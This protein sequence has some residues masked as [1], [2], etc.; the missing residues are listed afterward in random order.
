VAAPDRRNDVKYTAG[1]EYLAEKLIEALHAFLCMDEMFPLSTYLQNATLFNGAPVIACVSYFMT[2]CRDNLR[3]QRRGID[4]IKH[5]ADNQ[6]GLS[7]IAMHS[8]SSILHAARTLSDTLEVQYSFCK[9]VAAEAKSDDFARENFIRFGV[10]TLLVE[11][12]LRQHAE[13]SKQACMALTE[14]CVHD[15]DIIA[16]CQSAGVVDAVLAL[17]DSMRADYPSR[18][19]SNAAKSSSPMRSSKSSCQMGTRGVIW[20]PY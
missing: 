20:K 16:I 2:E 4:F 11:L 12:V 6:I 14:L 19:Y 5:F 15:T 18:R 7:S 3:V 10:E 1:A 17:I 13:Q 8:P 9:I